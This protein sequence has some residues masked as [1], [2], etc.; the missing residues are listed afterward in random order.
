M[1][2][3]KFATDGDMKWCEIRYNGFVLK[4][5]IGYWG[6]QPAGGYPLFIGLHSG[7]GDKS[8]RFTMTDSEWWKMTKQ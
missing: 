3:V 7:D 4:Y 8:G 2:P 6:T 1:A 5:T